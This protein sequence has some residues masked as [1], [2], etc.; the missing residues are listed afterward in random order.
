MPS[1]P[2]GASP[3]TKGGSES[4]AS[5]QVRA[6]VGKELPKLMDK[7]RAAVAEYEAATVSR[8]SPQPRSTPPRPAHPPA[9]A[10]IRV[11]RDPSESYLFH[12]GCPCPVRVIRDLSESSGIVFGA[13][14]V[15]R[16]A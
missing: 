16:G 8:P 2:P 7:L 14:A 15:S 1:S 9:P 6:M 3:R 10:A 11:V 12:S 4:R 13:S 5:R